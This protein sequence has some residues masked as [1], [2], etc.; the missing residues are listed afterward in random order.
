MQKWHFANAKVP[1]YQCVYMYQPPTA[2]AN[3][4]DRERER[5]GLRTRTVRTA[6]ANGEKTTE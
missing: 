2:N 6:D 3:G 5:C 4:A 1:L